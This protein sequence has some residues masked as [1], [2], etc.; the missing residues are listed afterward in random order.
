MKPITQE[1]DRLGFVGVGYMGRPIA[2]TVRTVDQMKA[3]VDGNPFTKVA[4]KPAYLCV[5]FLS[6]APTK[7]EVA[8]LHAQ[9]WKP[10]RNVDIVVNS[11]AGGAADRQ[12]RVVQ[13][14]LQALPGIPSITVT[15]EIAVSGVADQ[16]PAGTELSRALRNHSPFVGDGAA[17]RTRRRSTRAA[18]TAA[19]PSTS[20][21]RHID[22]R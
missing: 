7:A 15:I 20:F 12:A 1:N 19:R 17:V 13:K 5:T 14:A 4:T 22:A 9:D 8:P 3:V 11:G 10:E 16:C 6:H 18:A 21:N 2:T